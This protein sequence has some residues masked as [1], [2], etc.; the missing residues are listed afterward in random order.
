MAKFVKGSKA[1]KDFMAG[2]RAARKG[3]K[4]K[5]APKKR[6]ISG[7][8]HTD[9][10]SHNYKITI[11]AAGDY[12]KFEIST[13][14]AL[15]KLLKKPIKAVQKAVYD[16]K[17]LLDLISNSFDNKNTPLQTAKILKAHLVPKKEVKPLNA[18][19][20]LLTKKGKAQSSPGSKANFPMKL[21]ATVTIGSLGKSMLS[22]ISHKIDM[23]NKWKAVL[24]T[25][26]DEYKKAP[27]MY[28]G[29]IRTDIYRVKNVIADYKQQI[30]KLKKHI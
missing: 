14:K 6:K 21:P 18:F 28:K 23:L 10:K 5:A 4:K 8:K 16:S 27:K 7:S 24:V 19:V 30:V 26:K 1:A 2:L 22:E 15:A 20:N 12:A 3:A 11:G 9:I 17:N 25:L 13:I 29:A